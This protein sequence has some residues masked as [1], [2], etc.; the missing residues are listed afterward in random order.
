MIEFFKNLSGITSS[1][2]GVIFAFLI[3]K[4]LGY[5][6]ILSNIEEKRNMKIKRIEEIKIE[7]KSYKFLQIEY[8]NA[9]K[10]VFDEASSIMLSGTNNSEEEIIKKIIKEKEFFFL[11]V[12]DL[13]LNEYFISEEEKIKKI[14]KGKYLDELLEIK[15]D[16]FKEFPIIQLMR[17][18]SSELE[19][20]EFER[21]IRL[22]I[23]EIIKEKQQE[24]LKNSLRVNYPSLSMEIKKLQ[25][26][27]YNSNLKTIKM[28]LE[29]YELELETLKE[30][31]EKLKKMYREKE[32]LKRFTIILY[33][34]F[35]FGVIYPLSFL[36]FKEYDELDYSLHRNF[37]AELFTQSG[38]MLFFLALIITLC[39]Y[40]ILK[41]LSKKIS[42]KDLKDL[43]KSTDWILISYLKYKDY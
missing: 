8:D 20:S 40:F 29:K 13:D 5:E 10:E 42:N 16:L 36:K 41:T 43:N 35:I 23:N 7:I 30:E 26:I 12:D 37:L 21:K 18:Y 19:S 22:Y 32:I 3:G 6:D 14:L 9:V 17:K 25:N 33:I 34:L 11:D 28:L 4:I 24:R 38:I 39:I 1:M 2:I 31:K 27:S 15:S